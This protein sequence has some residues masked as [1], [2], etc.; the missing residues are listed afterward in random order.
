[1]VPWLIRT[2]PAHRCACSPSTPTPTTRRPRARPTLARYHAEGVRTVLV[3][4]TGGEEGELHNP[5]LREPGQPFH[6]LTP[7]QEK[8]DLAELRPLE[9]AAV[10]RGHRLR[11]G[12][13][14]RLPGLGHEGQPGQRRPDQLPPGRLRRGGRAGWWPSSAATRPQV[15]ITY[16]DDQQG[17]P[18]PDH[19]RVHDIS[20]PAF[21]RAGD[22]AWYP[23]LGEPWQPL[24]LYYTV[25]SRRRLLAVHEAL[26][27][28]RGS[29]PFDETWFE[30]PGPGRPHHHPDRRRRLP[31][32]PLG[33][34]AGPR[35]PG[36][37]QRGVLVR[38]VRR[39]AGRGVP[40]RGLDPGPVAGGRARP[41]GTLEDDLF[42]GV[43]EAARR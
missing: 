13:D 8:A 22:P 10:G 20:V 21:D 40:L 3:C 6:G 4:C 37:S 33:R 25:W 31:V 2:S 30:R 16:N 19:L 11:R 15:L 14:A 17:Y 26:L 42:A 1:M 7:E 34:A 9:L 12:G 29:S 43:R 39:G 28:L 35:H 32:G 18:H 23:E 38:A 36:R 41:P 24:K 27:R 5:S